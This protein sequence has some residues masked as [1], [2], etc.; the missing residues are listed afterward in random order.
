MAHCF[1]WCNTGRVTFLSM[2]SVLFRFMQTSL[3]LNLLFAVPLQAQA[4]CAPELHEYFIL[5]LIL[6][7][8]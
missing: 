7:N 4:Q 8:S 3:I 1:A 5:F 2:A 6:N